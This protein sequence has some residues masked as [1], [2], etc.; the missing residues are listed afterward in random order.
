MLNATE[1]IA[2]S[3][4]TLSTVVSP[5]IKTLEQIA[6][7]SKFSPFYAI[8]ILGTPIYEAYHVAISST[9]SIIYSAVTSSTGMV[10]DTNDEFKKILENYQG[11]LED[12]KNVPGINEY[13]TSYGVDKIMD[14]LGYLSNP[15]KRDLYERL[16]VENDIHWYNFLFYSLPLGTTFG[17]AIQFVV[18]LFKKTTKYLKKFLIADI[19]YEEDDVDIKIEMSNANKKL[20]QNEGDISLIVQKYYLGEFITTIVRTLVYFLSQLKGLFD[21]QGTTLEIANSIRVSSISGLCSSVAMLVIVILSFFL[22]SM[23]GISFT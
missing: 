14:I 7:I 15:K 18:N 13:I 10:T 23:Y 12:Y 9:M 6:N 11:I 19:V 22:T 16:I 3:S 4:Y 5:T 17:K 2:S 21:Y 1:K 8:P 20:I